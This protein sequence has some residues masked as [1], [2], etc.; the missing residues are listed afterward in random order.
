MRVRVERS[1]DGGTAERPVRFWLKER[2]CFVEEILDQWFGRNDTFYKVRADDQNLY[3]LRHAGSSN[4]ED[5]SLEA[6]RV[7][8]TDE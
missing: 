5:W 1:S 6:Y 3:I 4:E 2:R 8:E 7:G